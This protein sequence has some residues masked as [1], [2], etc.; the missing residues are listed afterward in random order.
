MF[1]WALMSTE[2]TCAQYIPLSDTLRAILKDLLCGKSVL[3][4]KI[5]TLLMVFYVIFMMDQSSNPMTCLYKHDASR[6]EIISL[7]KLFVSRKNK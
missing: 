6:Y 4:L 2:E 3:R 7:I 5:V 1:T